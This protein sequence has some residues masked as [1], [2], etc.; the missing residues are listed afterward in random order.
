MSTTQQLRAAASAALTSRTLW[1]SVVAVAYT[2]L[3]GE[4]EALRW[5]HLDDHKTQGIIALINI[6]NVL[7]RG[8][9]V[10]VEGENFR[11]RQPRADDAAAPSP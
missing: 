10:A 1:I 4:V 5:L 6:V 11:Q 3:T 2:L 8:R 9:T 7:S